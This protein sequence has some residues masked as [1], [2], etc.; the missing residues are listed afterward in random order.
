MRAEIT[1][2]LREIEE[3]HHVEVLNAC[4]SGSRAWG[5]PS[6]DSDYD[7][8]F[9]YKHPEA[10]YLKIDDDKDTITDVGAVLDFAGWELRKTMRLFR[11]SNASLYEKLRS[12][13]IYKEVS[14]FKNNLLH[15]EKEYYRPL[16]GV[17]HYLSL[18]KNFMKAYVMGEKVKLKKYF[19]VLRS[20]LAAKWIVAT[21]EVPPM[22]FGVLR[23]LLTDEKLIEWVDIMLSLKSKHGEALEVNRFNKVDSY[24][25]KTILEIED[26]IIHM[27]CEPKGKTEQ[28]N[29][30][31]RK[32]I[33]EH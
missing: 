19:Y 16:S 2:K 1:N 6:L 4:E 30:L 11:G 20:T 21:G 10:W 28:L 13:I 32:W 8:R 17:H 12:P 22:E 31:F 26:K 9:I 18:S 5:F 33:L 29:K 7:V 23:T 25:S 24:L 27:G 3:K 14:G 15:L